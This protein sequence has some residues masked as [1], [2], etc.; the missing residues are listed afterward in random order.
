M[1]MHVDHGYL[2]GYR[3]TVN[4]KIS[5]AGCCQLCAIMQP[6]H[7]TSA[8]RTLAVGGLILTCSENLGFA[9]TLFFRLSF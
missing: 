4:P 8:T 9:Q 3:P 7:E 1:G 6:L 2:L 5:C